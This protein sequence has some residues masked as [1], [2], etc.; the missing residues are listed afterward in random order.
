M[1]N[2]LPA[3]HLSPTHKK[4]VVCI[5]MHSTYVTASIKLSVS[6]VTVIMMVD[7]IKVGGV[8]SAARY[9]AHKQPAVNH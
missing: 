9:F 5:Y 3:V 2:L 4:V 6:G 1:N 7:K 8:V